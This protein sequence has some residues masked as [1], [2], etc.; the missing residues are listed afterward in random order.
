M[1]MR[2]KYPATDFPFSN[3]LCAFMD[4]N[5]EFYKSLKLSNDARFHFLRI[6]LT[7]MTPPAHPKSN[8]EVIGFFYL[9]TEKKECHTH[10]CICRFKQDFV[11]NVG[12]LE[13]EYVSYTTDMDCPPY[14]RPIREF[15]ELYGENGKYY[16][17]DNGLRWQ[18][19]YATLNDLPNEPSL[20]ADALSVLNEWSEKH[21]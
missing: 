12:S 5:R 8:D 3:A 10:H 4:T 13:T 17:D 9:D 19:H 16:H 7:S 1:K 20:K 15:F 18:H 11:V 2:Q 14:V 21:S 6:I